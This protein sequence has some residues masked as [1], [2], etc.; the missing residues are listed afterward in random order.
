MCVTSTWKES[1]PEEIFSVIVNYGDDEYEVHI[2]EHDDDWLQVVIDVFGKSD[3]YENSSIYMS[4]TP[5]EIFI[6]ASKY[7]CVEKIIFIPTDNF[8]KDYESIK[9]IPFVSSFGKIIDVLSQ[10]KP[11]MI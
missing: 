9:L 2:F 1:Y 7:K 6:N 5:S 3:D 4:K 11:Q 8:K 10:Y